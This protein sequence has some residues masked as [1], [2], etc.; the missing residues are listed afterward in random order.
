MLVTTT[1]AAIT[2]PGLPNLTR[3]TLFVRAGKRG[4]TD[5]YFVS[6]A[7]V[8]QITYS[9]SSSNASTAF[10]HVERDVLDHVFLP[11][12]RLAPPELDENVSRREAILFCRAL[13]EEQER[14]VDAGVAED[15]RVAVD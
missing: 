14:R 1:C 7:F 15:E 2:S 9:G 8:A 12:D 10:D 5:W 4:C 11:A 6:G 13:R 3:S